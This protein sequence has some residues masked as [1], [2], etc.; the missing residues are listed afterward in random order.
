M[1][2]NKEMKEKMVIRRRTG[3]KRRPASC[4]KGPQLLKN[5]GNC[6]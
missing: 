5:P 2:Q 1:I 4:Y 6:G 3:E